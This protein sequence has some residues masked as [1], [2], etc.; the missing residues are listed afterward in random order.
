MMTFFPYFSPSLWLFQSQQALQNLLACV[1]AYVNAEGVTRKFGL[2]V[3]QEITR[4]M[5]MSMMRM[6]VMV[7]FGWNYWEVMRRGICFSLTITTLD[8]YF[9]FPWNQA[10]VRWKLLGQQQ[11]IKLEISR[12][13]LIHWKLSYYRLFQLDLTNFSYS[14]HTYTDKYVK[15]TNSTYTFHHGR[16]SSRAACVMV[17]RFQ[18]VKMTLKISQ[19]SASHTACDMQEML[20]CGSEPIIVNT[21]LSVCSCALLLEHMCVCNYPQ[22][23]MCVCIA[24]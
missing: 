22:F 12:T 18:T 5:I 17:V 15:K 21:R 14:F 4:M 6:I 7:N 20:S 9:F 8:V 11:P 16:G 13:N 3:W 1:I 23:P 19:F 10:C 24:L 2:E